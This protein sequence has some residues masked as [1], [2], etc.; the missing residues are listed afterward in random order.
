MDP[1]TCQT[2][3]DSVYQSWGVCFNKDVLINHVL[4][5]AFRDGNPSLYF[6]NAKRF[7]QMTFPDHFLGLNYTEQD[8]LLR[9]IRDKLQMPIGYPDY[10]RCYH[11]GIWSYHR[12]GEKVSSWSYQRKRDFIM[13]TC[14]DAER[15]KPYD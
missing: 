14:F 9:R 13:A 8:G 10:P 7:M 12:Q 1:T 4:P 6:I 3:N 15:M 5:H 2:S 11:A